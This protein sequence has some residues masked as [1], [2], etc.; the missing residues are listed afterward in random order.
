[1]KYAEDSLRAAAAECV[2][3]AAKTTDPDAAAT[4]LLMAQKWLDLAMKQPTP[5]PQLA[6]VVDE[7][8]NRQM[9]TAH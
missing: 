5:N 4:L 2:Q 9:D 1:M 7:F 3:A 6:M 8:N